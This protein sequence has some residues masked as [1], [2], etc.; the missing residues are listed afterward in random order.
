MLHPSTRKLIEKL[1]EMTDKRRI[2]WAEGEEGRSVYDTEGYRVSVNAEPAELILSDALGKELERAD[3]ELLASTPA[4]SGGTFADIIS[5]MASEAQ[6][7]ARGTETAIET[8]LAG[9]EL[10]ETPEPQAEDI[11]ADLVDAEDIEPDETSMSEVVEDTGDET[12]PFDEPNMTLAVA[13]LADKVNGADASEDAP[14]DDEPASRQQL[15]TAEAPLAPE[16]ETVEETAET[17][18]EPTIQDA[19]TPPLVAE[20]D[21]SA[22]PGFAAELQSAPGS[23]EG[24]PEEARA[25]Q[26]QPTPQP[27]ESASAASPLGAFGAYSSFG[28]PTAPTAEPV[29]EPESQKADATPE[30]QTTDPEPETDPH[31]APASDDTPEDQILASV[32]DTATTVESPPEAEARST[33]EP[34]VESPIEPEVEVQVEPEAPSEPTPFT[35]PVQADPEPIA[36]TALTTAAEPAPA[37]AANESEPIEP[38]ALQDMSVERQTPFAQAQV[39]A[40]EIAETSEPLAQPVEP[41]TAT[42]DMPNIAETADVAPT[43][44]AEPIASEAETPATPVEQSPATAAATED[45]ALNLTPPPAPEAEDPFEPEPEEDLEAGDAPPKPATRFNPW[46]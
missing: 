25:E 35:S 45:E 19:A 8:V 46:M 3:A 42:D 41:A 38:T 37:A 34:D 22:A 43:I 26:G 2:T 4:D 6:R 23:D 12:R 1:Q 31:D 11:E 15:E 13:A 18:D 36:A 5:T 20:T 9:F 39:E 27:A 33:F 32:T 29:S 10:P 24:S 14:V 40:P 16:Q 44:A 17:R 28:A 30:T 21:V 7:I